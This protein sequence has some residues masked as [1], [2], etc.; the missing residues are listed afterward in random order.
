MNKRIGGLILVAVALIAMFA[1]FTLTT[2][3]F[4]GVPKA[5]AH[6]STMPAQPYILYLAPAQ[7]QR[8][9]LNSAVV[10]KHGGVPVPDW[11]AAQKAAQSRPLDALLVDTAFIGSASL[12]DKAW[13]KSQFHNGVVLVGLGVDDDQFAQTLGLNTFRVPQEANIPIGPMGYRLTMSLVQG[14]PGDV[15]LLGD[16]IDKYL[17]GD[18]TPVSGI[19]HPLFTVFTSTRGN[20]DSQTDIDVLFYNMFSSIKGAYDTRSEVTNQGQPK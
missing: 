10:Q 8:G 16:W 5:M 2:G 20:L 15:S 6:S 13:L 4:E 14:D 12:T 11:K 1:G 9:L 3:V 17:Q 7:A 18:D 19:Q